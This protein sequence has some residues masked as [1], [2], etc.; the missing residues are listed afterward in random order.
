MHTQAHTYTYTHAY[1]NVEGGLQSQTKLQA[2]L[3]PFNQI[4]KNRS[5]PQPLSP[6]TPLSALFLPHKPCFPSFPLPSSFVHI[7]IIF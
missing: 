1:T 7:L 2:G 4:F 6:P 3:S 5:L